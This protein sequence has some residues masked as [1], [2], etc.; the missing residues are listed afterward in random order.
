MKKLLLLLSGLLLA[1]TAL[2]HGHSHVGIMLNVPLW[3]AYY[4]PYYPPPVIVVPASPPVYVESPRP[5]VLQAQPVVA[6]PAAPQE[7]YWYY[8]AKP[9]GYYPYV[10]QCSTP[11]TKVLPRPPGQ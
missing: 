9:E 8:C 4:R 2:A 10:Q 7:N 11:W 1:Q 3:P 6:A 5:V